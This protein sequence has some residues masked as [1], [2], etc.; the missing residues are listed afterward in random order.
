MGKLNAIAETSVEE[1]SAMAWEVRSRSNGF[2]PLLRSNL[3]AIAETIAEEVSAI[4]LE[5]SA[6]MQASAF[7]QIE[8]DRRDDC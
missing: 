2:R 7:M 8:G 6:R 5:A 4:T 3:N 1:V